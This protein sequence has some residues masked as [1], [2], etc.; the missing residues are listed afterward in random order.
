[1]SPAGSSPRASIVRRAKQWA[2]GRFL[3]RVQRIT[4]RMPVE[5]RAVAPGRVLV[6]APH[7]DDEVI[8]AGGTMILH[9]EAGSALGV[10]FTT[11]SGGPAANGHRQRRATTEIRARE[12]RAVAD[13]FGFEILA[14]LPHPDGALSLHE[15]ALGRDLAEWIESWRPDQIFCPFPADHHRDHQATAAALGAAI[16]RAGWDGQ[17]WCYEVWSTLWPNV[18]ID[19]TRVVE[20]KREAISL[21]A[22]QVAGMDY[23][24]ATLGL[25]RYRGLRVR[26][27]SAEAF[28]VARAREY[29]HVAGTLSSL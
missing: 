19:I 12:A 28:F 4:H 10:V 27:P 20:A 16:A 2:A 8:G 29:L 15:P 21:Y 18:E 24:E 7:M 1:M 11:D 22:S 25:N 9:R 14:V 23:V 13:R 3:A 17:V 6:L 5:L 26:V